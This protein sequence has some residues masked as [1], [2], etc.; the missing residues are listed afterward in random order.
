VFPPSFSGENGRKIT[1][2]SEDYV[3]RRINEPTT[4]SGA[5]KLRGYLRRFVGAL[6]DNIIPPK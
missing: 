5:I 6:G 3:T 2:F 4:I 1:I